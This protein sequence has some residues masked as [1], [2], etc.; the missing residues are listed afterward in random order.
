MALV[1]DARSINAGVSTG[2]AKVRAGATGVDVLQAAGHRVTFRSD[3]LLCTIDGLPSTGCSAV[4]DTHY[5]AYFHR[6]PESRSWSYSNEGPSTYRPVNDST[7]G[8][9]YDDGTK[10]EPRPVPY[11]AICPPEAPTVSHSPTPTSPPRHLPS[12]RPRPI[13][14]PRPIHPTVQP[15]GRRHPGPPHHH[16]G[17]P[18]PVPSFSGSPPVRPTLHPT[19]GGGGNGGLAGAL[20]AAAIVVAIGAVTVLTNR[21]RSANL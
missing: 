4:D 14:S 9:V 3:G 1:V 10:L 21:R 8:W 6:A 19:G 11:H 5:W 18:A 13:G 7:E 16:T 2:C 17:T 15:T 20:I 12:H